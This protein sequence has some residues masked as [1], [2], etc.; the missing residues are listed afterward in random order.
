VNFSGDPLRGFRSDFQLQLEIAFFAVYGSPALYHI[1][2]D[3]ELLG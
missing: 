1:E 3:A 2:A